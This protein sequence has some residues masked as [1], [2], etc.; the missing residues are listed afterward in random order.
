MCTCK[1]TKSKVSTCEYT[2]QIHVYLSTCRY[3][4]Y[5]QVQVYLCVYAHRPKARCPFVSTYL[6][7]QVVTRSSLVASAVPEK[8]AATA[9]VCTSLVRST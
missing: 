3:F 1:Q 7:I 2:L 4:E 6:W 9:A 5:L 8:T